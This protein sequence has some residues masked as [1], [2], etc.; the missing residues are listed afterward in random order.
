MTF[1]HPQLIQ[2]VS[3]A[4]RL[5]LLIDAVADYGLYLLDPDGRVATWNSGAERLTGYQSH[6]ILG[7]PAAQF[8][9][10]E[11]QQAGL[12]A[13]ILEQALKA[14]RYEE[15]GWR[16]RKDGSTFRARWVLDAVR[17]DAGTVVGFAQTVREQKQPD[18]AEQALLSSE[19]Q[20][21]LLVD[22]IADHA[23]YML[24][25]SGIIINWNTGAERIKGY[26]AD[27][28]IGQ[29]FGR[30][31]AAEDRAR[32]APAAMLDAARRHGSFEAEGWRI[33]KDGSR[34]WA[35][36]TINPIHNEKGDLIGFG[37]ITR[38]IT[39]RREAQQ[40]LLDS[41]RQFRLLVTGVVDYA[42]YMLDPNGI[43]SN[44]NTGAERIK[45]YKA[46]EVLGQH[47]SKFYPPADRMAGVPAR[48]LYTAATEGKYEAEGW[49]LRKDGTRFWASVVID[50]LRDERG[51]LIGFAKITRDIT[52]RHEAQLALERAQVEVAH[53]QKM[54]AL[55]K[56]TAGVAHD[57]NNL[58]TITAGQAQILRRL[59]PDH[60]KA[61]RSIDAIE[62]AA[63]R[64]EHLT[65]Q[66]L[67]FS[68]RQPLNPVPVRLQERIAGIVGMLKTLVGA[69][70][71]LTTD[72]QPETWPV[73]ADL[74]E[75][76][77]A[78]VNLASNARDAMR[79][80]GTIHLFSENVQLVPDS[81]RELR[82]DFVALTVADTGSGIPADVL[83]KI[84]DPFFTTKDRGSG[85]GLG[86]SQV[87]GFANQSRGTVQVNSEPGQ[88]TFVTL[89]LPRASGERALEAGIEGKVPAAAGEGTI[90]L[91]EDDASVAEVTAMMLEQ[92]GY[93]VRAASSAATALALIERG[94]DRFDLVFS[95][96]VMDG[97]RD[98]LD[99]ARSL[100]QSH[101][102]LPVLLATGYSDISE[103]EAR[104]FPI[105]R[106][107]HRL[108]ELAA[109]IS[110]LLRGGTAARSNLVDL[111][112]ARRDREPKG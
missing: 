52:E 85:T 106:K 38:D 109:A 13:R 3:A 37:K 29:H 24:D 44:W 41:E 62:T 100:Q 22:G 69:E 39:E 19:R 74:N 90:L 43:V 56:L 101:P 60:L 36:V 54:E 53:A 83:P 2:S 1:D 51:V 75:L 6:D 48:A 59:L 93:R 96:V 11:D 68:R 77:L 70:V 72:I 40:A 17:D 8:F 110:N 47:F 55:G 111:E 50:A 26:R 25:P 76:E 18:A 92:L 27:E 71:T 80:A 66:L 89:Y 14:G 94:E 16:V 9:T 98:G 31:Y 63:Q 97:P 5:Q 35:L 15:E 78:L 34:F 81:I 82:G 58:L 45:G 57:F 84:F 91:V 99:L 104:D 7:R 28:I 108:N 67:T 87:Y 61:Q 46:D 102:A 23:L 105:L 4:E 49:R 20:F 30:F 103:S 10:R 107:P 88:G 86:L 79:G 12:P 65:R 112:Q 95:D 32:G 73:E 33:R 42:L 64:G 21:K